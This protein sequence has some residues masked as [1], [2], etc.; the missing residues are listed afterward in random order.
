MAKAT[1]PSRNTCIRSNL[2]ST[3]NL[4]VSIK[5]ITAP[6]PVVTRPPKKA[7]QELAMVSIQINSQVKFMNR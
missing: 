6:A 4:L 7:N 2:I 5:L 1:L 3:I